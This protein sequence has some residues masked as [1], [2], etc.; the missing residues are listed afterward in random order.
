M[1]IPV[2]AHN[3]DVG[4]GWFPNMESAPEPQCPKYSPCVHLYIAMRDSVTRALSTS[5][6]TPFLENEPNLPCL[7]ES[8]LNGSFG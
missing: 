7:E 1:F 3:Q 6:R 2:Q 4:E 5:L 8:S